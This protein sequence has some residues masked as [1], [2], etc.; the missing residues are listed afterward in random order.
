MTRNDEERNTV[1]ADNTVPG[2]VVDEGTTGELLQEKMVAEDI[3]RENADES[4][5][6][7]DQPGFDDG[8]LGGHDGEDRQG[9]P[10]NRLGSDLSGEAE[11]GEGISRS[12]GV[13]GGPERKTPL[14]G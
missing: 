13:D 1:P 5:N 4:G 11:G 10:N 3:L 2:E 14:P 8:R 12:G 9:E 7:N 6:V